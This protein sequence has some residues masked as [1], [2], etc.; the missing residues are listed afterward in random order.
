MVKIVY[1]VFI[2]NIILRR[3]YV[4][5]YVEFYNKIFIRNNSKMVIAQYLENLPRLYLHYFE[6][7]CK[8]LSIFFTPVRLNF[9]N[10]VLLQCKKNADKNKIFTAIK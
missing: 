3:F 4:R 7:T 1:I 8:I 9:H 6:R 2:L 10:K 5:L